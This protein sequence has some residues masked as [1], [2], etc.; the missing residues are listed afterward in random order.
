MAR[1][2][3][4]CHVELNVPDY[5]R[6]IQFYDRMFGWLGY[7]SFWTLGI[8]SISTYYTAY[9]HSYIGIQPSPHT[10]HL[11]DSER[12]C[13]INHVALWAKNR[14][15]VDAFYAGFL[16]PEGLA[17]P[18]PPDWCWEYAPDYYAVFFF[19][20][21]GIRWELVHVPLLPSPV[22]IYKWWRT[23]SGIW[24]EHPEWKRHP[25]PESLRKLPRRG[26]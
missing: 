26:N 24:K 1:F 18:D 20:P 25:F 17:V 11:Q 7:S 12:R 22:A 16:K 21:Y 8:G 9:P 10:E 2:R 13:G 23:L 3:G 14:R 5:E 6:A 15:E 19:D 4:V